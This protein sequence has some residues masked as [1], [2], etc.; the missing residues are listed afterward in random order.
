MTKK[1]N[2]IA[3]FDSFVVFFN[4]GIKSEAAMYIKPPA[5]NGKRYSTLK[6]PF[7][8]YPTN[9]PAIAVNDVKKL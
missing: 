5:A 1:A 8:K 3:D 4:S 7:K 9:A 2:S 6:L